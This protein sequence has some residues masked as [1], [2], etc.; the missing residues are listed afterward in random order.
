MRRKIHESV[1]AL[2]AA[3]I[4]FNSVLRGSR[5]LVKHNGLKVDF[6]PGTGAFHVRQDN[7]RK[8]KTTV[9]LKGVHD[10]IKYLTDY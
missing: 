8:L 5:L 10:L 3:K 6:W 4:E 1:E 2:R 9:G 7:N